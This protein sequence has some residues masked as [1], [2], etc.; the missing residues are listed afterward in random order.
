MSCE[1]SSFCMCVQSQCPM[2]EEYEVVLA[3]E[4]LA[5]GMDGSKHTVKAKRSENPV[6][7][8]RSL[9]EQVVTALRDITDDIEDVLLE[10]N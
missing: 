8:A 5:G 2:E 3:A 7:V 6:L 9:L 4:A 10:E 1:I